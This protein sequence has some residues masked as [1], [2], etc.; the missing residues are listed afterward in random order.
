MRCKIISD[1]LPIDIITLTGSKVKPDDI[2]AGDVL[3]MLDKEE[4]A[5]IHSRDRIRHPE[6]IVR[7][8]LKYV[9]L[10]SRSLQILT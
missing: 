6:S 1:R 8:L 7:N 3:D 2:G 9:T 10:H 5:F 4:L